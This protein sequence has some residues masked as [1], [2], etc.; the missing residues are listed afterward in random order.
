MSRYI[1]WVYMKNSAQH[2]Y[3][4]AKA[5][6]WTKAY[7]FMASDIRSVRTFFGK[8]LEDSH[9]IFR[10]FLFIES[11]SPDVSAAVLFF[12]Q[13]T[14]AETRYK[15]NCDE[16]GS[17]ERSDEGYLTDKTKLPVTA[18]WF[19]DAGDSGERGWHSLGRLECYRTG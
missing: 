4:M 13:A 5:L 14:C 16:N 10:Q 11:S 12:L 6:S 17:N 8:N 3:C 9:N 15:C 18:M 2:Y 1:E 19:G 7:I